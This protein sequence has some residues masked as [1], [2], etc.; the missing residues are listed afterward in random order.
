MAL[1]SQDH[2][3]GV[4]MYKF[5]P[6]IIFLLFCSSTSMSQSNNVSKNTIKKSDTPHLV[7]KAENLILGNRVLLKE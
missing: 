1:K 2:T 6:I 5:I 3:L 7:T 4:I